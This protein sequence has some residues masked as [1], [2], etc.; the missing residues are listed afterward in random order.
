MLL[1]WVSIQNHSWSTLRESHLS[2][3]ETIRYESFVGITDGLLKYITSYNL[4][5]ENI[6]VR[7]YIATIELKRPCHLADHTDRPTFCI[8]GY[9]ALPNKW[10]PPIYSSKQERQRISP[11]FK[12]THVYPLSLLLPPH[13]PPRSSYLYHLTSPPLL[14]VFIN[15]P[16]RLFLM[17]LPFWLILIMTSALALNWGGSVFL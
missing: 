6:R 10:H 14:R 9:M 7:L 16:V 4:S 15:I 2:H 17:M 1:W 8:V 12:K 13:P 11:F 3:L 5:K